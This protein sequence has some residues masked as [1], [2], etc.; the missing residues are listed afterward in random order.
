MSES[1]MM[2][3]LGRT[4]NGA[5]DI[6][7]STAQKVAEY[8][9]K[10]TL[11]KVNDAYDEKAK[12]R[13]RNDLDQKMRDSFK[14]LAETERLFKEHDYK[15]DQ[16]R[17]SDEHTKAELFEKETQLKD[18]FEQQ[19]REKDAFFKQQEQRDKEIFNDLQQQRD[20]FFAKEDQQ[21]LE[22]T[23][24]IDTQKEIDAKEREALKEQRLKETE[25]TKPDFADVDRAEANRRDIELKQLDQNHQ[26]MMGNAKQ[27]AQDAV[28]KGRLDHAE[29]DKRLQDLA[30][31][32]EQE[33]QALI[34]EQMERMKRFE[35]L[36][37]IN[38]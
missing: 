38:R 12:E 32:L 25:F 34:R 24:D 21:R 37:E 20:S 19:D 22:A 15:L 35:Q 14:E 26:E 36:Y 18:L 31:K 11:D 33:R 1:E 30:E 27:V 2:K 17:Q 13:E 9:A 28:D 10:P 16:L 6:A 7:G 8:Y 5:M 23:K 3:A 4:I 29:A